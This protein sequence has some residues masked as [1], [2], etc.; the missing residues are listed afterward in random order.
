M[1]LLSGK[2]N[3]GFDKKFAIFA[4]DVDVTMLDIF[5]NIHGTPPFVFAFLRDNY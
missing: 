4:A 1:T 2:K 5:F 3:M